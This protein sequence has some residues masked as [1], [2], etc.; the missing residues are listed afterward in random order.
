MKSIKMYPFPPPTNFLHII[1][2]S[3]N[4]YILYISFISF[5]S[6]ALEIGTFKLFIVLCIMSQVQYY[7]SMALLCVQGIT[8]CLWH[9]YVFRALL[10]VQGITM[11]SGHYYVSMAL[12]WV[13]GITMCSGH[14]YVSRALVW[15]QGII[16]CLWHYY[17]F[18]ALLCVQ[19]ITMYF[20]IYPHTTLKISNYILSYMFS[21]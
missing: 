4:M 11:C 5:I 14:Y 7:V 18:R 6:N 9:Y 21:S 15:V 17:V 10:Y 8:M 13:Q 2:L 1:C 3:K 20:G 12:V 16:M 19:G